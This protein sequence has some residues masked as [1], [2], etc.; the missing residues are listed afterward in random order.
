MV[1][2]SLR[3]GRIVWRRLLVSASTA[4][5]VHVIDTRL[6][7]IVGEFASGD[8]PHESNSSLCVAGTMS[9]YAAIVR[10]RSFKYKLVPV[11]EKPYGSTNSGDG[12]RCFVSLSGDDA[13]SVIS[14]RTGREV[15]RIAVGDH[16]QRM[17]MGKIRRAFVR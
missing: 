11:D 13:V 16:P 4:R 6:G 2:I 1:A 7:R 17:R 3:D 14:C 15:A 9:D 10:R 5:K 8:Q 12:R